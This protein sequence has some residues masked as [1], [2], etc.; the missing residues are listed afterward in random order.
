[1][2]IENLRKE[3]LDAKRALQEEETI[4]KRQKIE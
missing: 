2:T 1:M 3:V 4:T